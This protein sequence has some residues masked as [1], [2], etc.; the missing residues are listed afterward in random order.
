MGGEVI[1]MDDEHRV[2][3]VKANI[4]GTDMYLGEDGTFYHKGDK[5]IIH[6]TRYQATSVVLCL[7]RITKTADFSR[8]KL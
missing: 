7:N 8:E 1:K 5:D 6:F 2:Y 4:R 3:K